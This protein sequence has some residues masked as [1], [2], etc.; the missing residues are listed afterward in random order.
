V[1][2]GRD[3]MRLH[4]DALFTHDAAGD[5]FRVNEPDG[6][7]APRFFLGRTADGPVWHV[8][9]DVDHEIRL[10]LDAAVQ[11]DSLGIRAIDSPTNPLPY[12]DILARVAPVQRTWGGPAFCF[13]PGLPGNTGAVLVTEENARLLHSH[14][15]AWVADISQCAPMFALSVDGNAVALCCSVRRTHAA[16]E[17]GVESAP[18]YRGRGYSAQV[19]AAWARG[20]RDMARVPLYSTSWTNDASRAVARKLGLIGFGCDMH[21]T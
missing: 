4:I 19:V 21:I 14:F 1:T 6:P 2:S 10:A 8:R 5:L 17:A 16:H 12:E 18:A 20:V 9:H 7:P 13:P 15:Q 11:E 3:L